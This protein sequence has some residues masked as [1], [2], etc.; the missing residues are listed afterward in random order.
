MQ[1]PNL[2]FEAILR[3]FYKHN[4]DFIVVGGVCGVLHGAPVNTF[5]I[6]FVHSR[7]PENLDK[8]LD[9]LEELGAYYREPGNRRLQ[10][11]IKVL[12]GPNPNLFNTKLGPLD[13]LGTID[14]GRDYTELLPE[15]TLLRLADMSVRIMNLEF[16]IEVKRRAGRPKDLIAIPILEGALRRRKEQERGDL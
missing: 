3:T 5:D 15:S 2:D 12:A 9:A 14:N 10:P 4:V 6:D 8:V 1:A 11:K 16:L 13:L 7:E